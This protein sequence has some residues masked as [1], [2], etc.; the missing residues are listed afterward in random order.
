MFFIRLVA[1]SPLMVYKLSASILLLFSLTLHSQEKSN[2]KFGKISVE[3]LER[4][5]YS[6]DSGANAVVIAKIGFYDFE[7]NQEGWFDFNRK[8][9]ERIH[10]LNKG[11]YDEANIEIRLYNSGQ[12][13]EEIVSLKAITYNLENGKVVET[14]LENKSVFEERL[15]KNWMLKKFTFPNVKEGSIVEYMVNIRSDYFTRPDAWYFQGDIPVLWSDLTFRIPEFFNY[16]FIT[17]GYHPFHDKRPPSSAVNNFSVMFQ[18]PLEPGETFKRDRVSF[19]AQVLDHRWVMK[20][21]PALKLENFTSSLGNHISKIEFQLAETR[22]PLAP[23]S[24]MQSWPSLTSHLLQ[25]EYFGA[26]LGKGDSWMMDELGPLI[27]NAQTDEQKARSIYEFVRD[28]FTC[29]GYNAVYMQQV[30]RNVFKS[31]KGNVAEIN[32]LLV[33]MLKNAGLKS[34]PVMLSTRDHGYTYPLYPL[35]DKF[36]YVIA[37]VLVNDKVI[38]LDATRPWM[39]FGKLLPDIYNGHARM[40]NQ[41]ATPLEF[42]T[43]S[44][45]EKEITSIMLTNT[46][47]GKLAGT[48][49]QTAGHTKAYYVRKEVKEK[50]VEEY[51]NQIKK[52]FTGEVEIRDKSIDSLRRPDDP[53]VIRYTF[54]LS[55]ENEDMIYFNPMLSEALKENPFKSAVR[56][57]PVE[58]PFAMDD[59]YIFRMD[60]PAGYAVEELPKSTRF[61][62]DEEGKSFFEYLISASGNVISMRS[63][64]KMDRTFYSHEEYDMLREFFGFIVNKHSEQIVFKKKN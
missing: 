26:Q 52:G 57:Y 10:I 41:E 43:D 33:S 62:F 64:L 5:V 18:R 55:H 20:D 39:G 12:S 1:Q 63:R 27:K 48:F 34:E 4:K 31:R 46:D 6:V 13:K 25:T 36:N 29:T 37:A 51:F 42:S 58:M 3:D 24:I 17:E 7:G 53:L 49:Q 35:L 19:S 50:G 38:Y 11:G 15:N 61:N 54:S 23:Q 44:L 16:V 28:N 60:V 9:H 22:Q 47:D 32:L 56:R 40:V 2:I 14:K 8:I 30:L 21:V 45:A 59:V